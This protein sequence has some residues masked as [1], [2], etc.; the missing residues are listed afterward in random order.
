[1]LN[2]LVFLATSGRWIKPNS[3]IYNQL[4]GLDGL[5]AT[6]DNSVLDMFG[7]GFSN[8]VNSG[9]ELITDPLRWI[10]TGLGLVIE[11]MFGVE[12]ITLTRIFYG[13]LVSGVTVN[14]FA[15]E[16]ASGNIYGI[17]GAMVYSILRVVVISFMV[18]VAA[19]ILC[20]GIW[21]GNGE[22]ALA[23]FRSNLTNY[24]LCAALLFL[25]PHIVEVMLYAKDLI[26]FF[27]AQVLGD[28]A[29]G[30]Y[31]GTYRQM[32]TSVDGLFTASFTP[33]D[34]E[35]WTSYQYNVEG[36]LFA[37]CMYLGMTGMTL[38]LA[39]T[40]VTN[41][42][43]QMIAFAFFPLVALVSIKD[44]KT[45]SKW[46]SSM[47]ALMAVPIVDTVLFMIPIKFAGIMDES[48]MYGGSLML[49]I[50]CM[51][52]L[53][54]RK[55]IRNLI[56][57]ETF[58]SASGIAALLMVG[59]MATQVAG[60][61]KNYSSSMSDVSADSKRATM[62]KELAGSDMT[63]ISDGGVSVMSMT[64]GK[65]GNVD[66]FTKKRAETMA[67]HVD[68]NSFEDKEFAN[69]LSDDQ[70]AHFYEQRAKRAYYKA[71]GS[72]AG[73]TLGALSGFSLGMFGGPAVQMATTSAG[74]SLGG[75]LGARFAGNKEVPYKKP[76]ELERPDA[77]VVSRDEMMEAMK[78]HAEYEGEYGFAPKRNLYAIGTGPFKVEDGKKG[79]GALTDGGTKAAGLLGTAVKVKLPVMAGDNVVTKIG[80][81]EYG[82]ALNSLFSSGSLTESLKVFDNGS[83]DGARRAAI[84]SITND[85]VNG[86]GAWCKES[87]FQGNTN[88]AFKK[89]IRS[90]L[91][92]AFEGFSGGSAE[93]SDLLTNGTEVAAKVGLEFVDIGKGLNT[94]NGQQERMDALVDKVNIGRAQKQFN[95]VE[96]SVQCAKSPLWNPDD[97]AMQNEAIRQMAVDC[98][99]EMAAKVV[100]DASPSSL[101]PDKEAEVIR[102][103]QAFCSDYN[104]DELCALLG[105]DADIVRG[106]RIL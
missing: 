90:A 23:Q 98:V 11:T 21:L 45:L 49:F 28:T 19:F 17:T 29:S 82:N 4:T 75:T 59:R 89:S 32:A 41:A 95:T 46:F 80:K 2:R 84:N 66:E 34:K 35:W 91:D 8:F 71:T 60:A 94:E 68:I 12:G 27:I 31:I 3:G 69:I 50:T 38:Y 102:L 15:F 64:G 58:S 40:Y 1:M 65:S 74:M 48:G 93:F 42:L 39:Y 37:G 9:L 73:S 54:A 44:T 25:M 33:V 81:E 106:H 87:G 36:S 63:R 83:D 22:R 100:E 85:V 6:S 76:E 70:K 30:D 7:K 77:E 67:K 101:H 18:I 92:K 72:M 62:Y 78:Q 51:G 10:A 57:G 47:I 97:V 53:P 13:R 56:G 20:K 88:E 16:L 26:L 52:I 43:S 61:A 86:Y 96:F 104:T 5:G 79:T 55:V 99:S 103:T 24:L 105:V 14:K